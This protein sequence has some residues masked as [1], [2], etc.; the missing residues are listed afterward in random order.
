MNG[1][2]GRGHGQGLRTAGVVAATRVRPL[3]A[4][5]SVAHAQ[6]VLQRRIKQRVLHRARRPLRVFQEQLSADLVQARTGDSGCPV[7]AIV[8]ACPLLVVVPEETGGARMGRIHVLLPFTDTGQPQVT[9]GT[10]DGAGGCGG[11]CFRVALFIILGAL[12]WLL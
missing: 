4:L 10:G 5:V 8:A 7:E 3:Q 11:E 1:G 6:V 9:V 2:G 12:L